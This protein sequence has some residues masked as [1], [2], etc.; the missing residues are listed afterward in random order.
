MGSRRHA[1]DFSAIAHWARKHSFALLGNTIFFRGKP[2]FKMMIQ[3]ASEVI[4]FHKT[5]IGAKVLNS[6][7]PF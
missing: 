7:P 4:N 3:R 6:I 2:P 1:G 5:Y